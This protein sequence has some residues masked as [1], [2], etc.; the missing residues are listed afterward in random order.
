MRSVE[1]EWHWQLE[2]ESVRRVLRAELRHETLAALSRRLGVPAKSLRAIVRAGEPNLTQEQWQA[3][4]AF[5]AAH[6]A[7]EPQP[8]AVA[9]AVLTAA[10]PAS[11]REEVRAGLV[12]RLYKAYTSTGA[13]LPGW[14]EDELM[15][16]RQ[17]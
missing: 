2:H 7:R 5:R 9:V 17:G 14:I 13:P 16:E 8:G 3:L 12:R 11:V 15:A 6:P 1:S 10:L 4:D